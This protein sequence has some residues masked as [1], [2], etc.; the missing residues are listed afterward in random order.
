MA[1]DPSHWPAPLVAEQ[2]APVAPF[3]LEWDDPA[4]APLEVGAGGTH[5]L[6]VSGAGRPLDWEPSTPHRLASPLTDG[7]GDGGLR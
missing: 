5:P 1:H 4:T 3:M 7:A 6:F 2:A